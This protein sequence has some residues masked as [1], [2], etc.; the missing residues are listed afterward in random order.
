MGCGGRGQARGRHGA[1]PCAMAVAP[2]ENMPCSLTHLWEHGSEPRVDHAV[3]ALCR[4]GGAQRPMSNGGSRAAGPSV[5]TGT[6][7]AAKPG[8]KLRRLAVLPVERGYSEGGDGGSCGVAAQLAQLLLGCELVQ[9]GGHPLIHRVGGIQP[10]AHGGSTAGIVAGSGIG[11]SGAACRVNT[12]RQAGAVL[13]APAAGASTRRGVKGGNGGSGRGGPSERRQQAASLKNHAGHT[14][15]DS[16][17]Q[18]AK[19]PRMRAL[20]ISGQG[21]AHTTSQPD[22]AALFTP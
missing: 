1:A 5:A 22:L 17:L 15:D 6:G 7:R 21:P 18:I 14:G 10:R 19:Q 3:Q 2:P 4:A 12:G 9:Q 16:R 11:I 8:R 20:P 13:V